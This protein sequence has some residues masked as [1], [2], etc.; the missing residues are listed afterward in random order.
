MPIMMMALCFQP[1]PVLASPL[2][3]G[4]LDVEPHAKGYSQEWSALHTMANVGLEG[5]NKS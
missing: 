3:F 4:I 5:E 2:G 1:L